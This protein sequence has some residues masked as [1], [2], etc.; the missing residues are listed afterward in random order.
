MTELGIRQVDEELV[1]AADAFGTTPAR[2]LL[3]VQLPLAL[4][5][6]MAGVNQVIMLA[7]SMVVIA[8]MVGAGGLGGDVYQAISQ[9]DV[10]LGF[11]AGVAIVI[12]AMYLDRM[13]GALGNQRLPARPP[14]RRQGAGRAS[15]PQDAGHYRPRP[16]VAVVGVVVLALVAGGMGI[17]GGNDERPPT[18]AAAGRRQG[19]DDQHRLHPLGR[20]RRLHLPLE[21]D[22]G[23]A[24]LPG[25]TPSSSTPAPLYTCLAAGNVDF[26]TDAWL[27]TTHAAYWK[28]YGSKLDDLGAWYGKTSLELSRPLVREGRRLP[29]RPQGQGRAV[30]RE[31]HRHRVRAPVRWPCCKSKVLQG[32]GLD[33]E[34]KV[35]DSST[36]AML[37]ELK[38]AYAKKEPDRRHALVAALGVQ[39]LRAEEA[40]GPQGRLGQGRRHAHA[41]PQGLRGRQP[42]RR[43]VAEELQA[44]REAAHQP[45]GRDQ[46][47]GQGQGSRRP[48]APG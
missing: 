11:E 1:E 8:G 24:R 42:G 32:Y 40:E 16:Q 15:G 20:G 12:L 35:V 34:Y 13:T 4:P 27:P 43:Q 14:R 39:R 36:P 30:R 41:G 2:T 37:A 18:V 44:E 22:P 29:G 5:T 9:L 19:Q 38:R 23:A 48:C 28:K 45:R 47:G 31:D 21:G 3:R 33:K 17:F 46:Q 7:L 25:R 6:I 26:Q 10:G